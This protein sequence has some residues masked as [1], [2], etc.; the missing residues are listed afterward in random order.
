ML[1]TKEDRDMQFEISQEVLDELNDEREHELFS[2]VAWES[3]AFDEEDY[4][5]SSPIPDIIT[6]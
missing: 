1:L 2:L 5:L 3:A 6:E 4:D